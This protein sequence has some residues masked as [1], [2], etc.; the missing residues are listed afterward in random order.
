[1][2][3]SFSK[4]FLQF[5][6]FIGALIF[7]VGV[8]IVSFTAFVMMSQRTRDIGLMKAAGCPNNLIFGYFLTELLIMAFL[9]CLF[10]VLLGVLADFA[11][12]SLLGNF[13]TQVPQ[14]LVDVWLLVQVFLLFFVLAMIFG[15]KPVLDATKIEPAKTISPTQYFG[16]TKAPEFKAIKKS[17]VVKIA[18]RSLFRRKSATIRIVLCL[19]VVFILATITITGGIIADQTTKNWVEKAVGRDTLLIGHRE[20]C[21]QYKLLLSKFYENKAV[22]QFT[23]TDEKYLMP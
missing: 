19:T 23:Y 20:V 10:G 4:I 11:S 15:L 2:T 7:I 21:S 17:L 16:L 6:Y 3:A 22:P 18:S 1:M 5:M 14:T 12:A 13:G 8:V 9:S